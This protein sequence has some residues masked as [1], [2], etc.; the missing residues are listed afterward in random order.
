LRDGRTKDAAFLAGQVSDK[1]LIGT[2]VTPEI[3]EILYSNFMKFLARE[4]PGSRR[5]SGLLS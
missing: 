4:E 2:G 5:F 3:V 1:V